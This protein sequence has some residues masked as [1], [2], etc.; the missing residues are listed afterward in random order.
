MDETDSNNENDSSSK[1]SMK[2]DTVEEQNLKEN[3]TQNSNVN[4]D[5]TCSKRNTEKLSKIIKKTFNDE[6]KN[7]KLKESQSRGNSEKSKNE[8]EN[9]EGI[10]KKP[11]GKKHDNIKNDAKSRAKRAEKN[12]NYGKHGSVK[13]FQKGKK[14]IKNE[15]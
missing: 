15:L 7:Q 3:V 11:I 5:K 4:T 12:Q 9:F 6:V 14:N 13:K 2:L 10:N 8:G 1:T